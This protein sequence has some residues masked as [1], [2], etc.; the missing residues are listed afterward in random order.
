MRNFL[1]CCVTVLALFAA[2]LPGA[3]QGEIGFALIGTENTQTL[4]EMWNP[5]LDDMSAAVGI[6]VRP[7]A[8]PDYSGAIW[9]LKT[10]KAQIAWLGNKTAIL[11]VDQAQSEVAFIGVEDEG[12]TGYSA[13]LITRSDSPFTTADDVLKH[14][15][16]V[17]FALGDP[18]STSGYTVPSYYL[19]AARRIDPHAA[20]KRLI[21]G[22]HEE[23]FL[24]VVHGQADV[25]TINSFDMKR[26]RAKHPDLYSGVRV[27]WNSPLIPS[28][29]IVWRKDLPEA[30]KKAIRSFLLQFGQPRPG[31]D[32][33]QQ[34]CEQMM[35]KGIGRSAFR[36]SDD[37]QLLQT[38]MLELF[39]LKEQLLANTSFSSEVREVKLREVDRR[40]SKLR[41]SE[42]ERRP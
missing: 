20:F 3:A 5:I 36:V 23:N 14:A 1:Q 11:A 7:M 8:F 4:L 35:L 27:I 37:R 31:K 6:K 41:A 28:D 10:N 13:Q 19:F 9:A 15:S 24:A 42:Q 32:Q 33:V 21:R 18:N 29:P 39:T 40:M 30:R 2:A 16:T 12:E 17:T 34:E 25:A 38:R 26:M 22:S